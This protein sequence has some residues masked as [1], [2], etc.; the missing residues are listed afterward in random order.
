[1]ISSSASPA[2]SAR[3]IALDL[4]D[5]GIPVPESA[6]AA[7][8]R[9]LLKGSRISNYPRPDGGGALAAAIAEAVNRERLEIPDPGWVVVTAGASAGIAAVIMALTAPGDEVLIPDPGYP[10]FARLVSG[11]GRK[12]AYYRAVNDGG[13]PDPELA[14][15]AIT[16]RTRLLIWNSPSNPLG[17][18]A[19]REE[20][21]AAL[22]LAEGRGIT[23]LADD[24]YEH[25]VFD[26]VHWSPPPR[27]SDLAVSVHSFS[28][29]YGMAGWRLG[30]V[31]A[32]PAVARRVAQAHWLLVKGVSPLAEQAALGALQAPAEYRAGVLKAMRSR[33]DQVVD[34][35]AESG[36][37]VRAPAGAIY[38]WLGVRGSGLRSEEFVRRCQEAEALALA[39]GTAFG[40]SGEG[41]VR[42]SFGAPE[43]DL[44]EGTERLVRFL[45]RS[46]VRRAL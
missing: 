31:V 42:L 5:P 46:G 11:L 40:P 36:I 12:V 34:R 14:G 17:F 37:E 41:F 20:T 28:K 15:S 26:G 30:H 44:R 18:V 22:R 43:A 45:L 35:L 25:L 39:P 10:A 16:A 4:G 13:R 29:S 24:V 32:P 27:S 1:M 8:A 9:F 7:A 2:V 33:R 19:T 6:I 3:R 38:L 21:E 23:F